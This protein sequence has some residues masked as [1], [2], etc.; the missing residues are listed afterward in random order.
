MYGA[1]TRGAFTGFITFNTSLRYKWKPDIV[2]A[3]NVGPEVLTGSTRLKCG[4]ATKCVLNML[5]TLSLVQYGKCFE[6]LMV[7]LSPSNLKLKDRAFRIVL[8][9]TE[10][11]PGVDEDK[12][13]RTL[14]NNGYDIRTT[15]EQL[16]GEN[17]AES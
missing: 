9:M 17:I 10:G 7:D 13:Y 14:I 8:L 12:A 1:H 2:L 5:S 16:R 4:S 15:V 11:V 6:N 3:M